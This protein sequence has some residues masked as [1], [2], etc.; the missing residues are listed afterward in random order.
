MCSGDRY[1]HVISMYLMWNKNYCLILIIEN[2]FMLHTVTSITALLAMYKQAPSSWE[3]RSWSPST[4]FVYVKVYLLL[5]VAFH[6]NW[7]FKPQCKPTNSPYWSSYISCSTSAEKFFLLTLTLFMFGDQFL[8]SDD[9]IK[10]L[11]L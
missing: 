8:N 10:A 5:K 7:P 2:N 3:L 4:W 1:I 9:Q 11:L 6:T